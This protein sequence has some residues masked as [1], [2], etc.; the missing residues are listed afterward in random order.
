MVTRG[1][2]SHN[3]ATGRPVCGP[4]RAISRLDCER[5][6]TVTGRNAMRSGRRGVHAKAHGT[7]C[8]PLHT[9]CES[10]KRSTQAGRNT[11]MLLF[12]D[13]WPS[14]PGSP[15]V[16]DLTGPGTDSPGSGSGSRPSC[17]PARPSSFPVR[18][19]V[20]PA[21]LLTCPSA[22][23]CSPSTWGVGGGAQRPAFLPFPLRPVLVG[24]PAVRC[25]WATGGLGGRGWWIRAGR[26]DGATCRR[27][28]RGRRRGVPPRRGGS[29][30]ALGRCRSRRSSCP[31]MRRS[32]R[33]PGRCS[34]GP[35]RR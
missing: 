23:R 10:T 32:R 8:F 12:V 33:G 7:P 26:G 15:T 14:R 29:P 5:A 13:S 6:F 25:S 22:S 35:C 30:S 21:F 18:G 27:A 4:N 16:S 34:R 1:Q 17:L 20:R 28:G 3:V 2:W 19:G 11:W 9:P 24:G 31:R